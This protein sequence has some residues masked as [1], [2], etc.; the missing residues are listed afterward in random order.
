MKSL[1]F[2]IF[3]IAHAFLAKAFDSEL[4][5]S[6][7]DSIT[8]EQPEN[9][10]EIQILKYKS[11]NIYYIIYDEK[12]SNS[13]IYQIGLAD[14]YKDS[15]CA[16]G[17]TCHFFSRPLRNTAVDDSQLIRFFEYFGE[18]VIKYLGTGIN[19]ITS[20]CAL[21]NSKILESND[22]PSTVYVDGFFY[23]NPNSKLAESYK[24]KSI[25]IHAKDEES[26]LA[27][28]E[29][30]KFIS[31]FY[32]K[33]KEA[34]DIFAGVLSQYM[35]NKNL[36]QNNKL[37]ARLRIAWL[38]SQSPENEKWLTRDYEYVKNLLADAGATLTNEKEITSY[39]KVK[40]VLKQS[41]F[42]IDIS[43]GSSGE[44]DMNDFYD[45]Y[46]YDANDSL[47]LLKEQNI[48][49]ND[50]TRS[51]EGIRAWE[52]DY[53]AF[54]HLVL[55]DL[56]YW[57]HPKLFL[58]DDY[59][60][61]IVKRLYGG[62]SVNDDTPI[63][64]IPGDK[65]LE[66]DENSNQNVIKGNS[67]DTGDL[68]K[69]FHTTH[70]VS[71]YWFRNIAKNTNI[72]TEPKDRCPSLLSEYTTNNICLSDTYFRG[73]YDEYAMFDDVV[74]QVKKYAV[75]YYPIIGCVILG[76]FILALIFLKYLKRRRLEKKGYS[77]NQKILDDNEG[78]VEI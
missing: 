23:T 49:R 50:A 16:P 71:S 61:N 4:K 57:F 3:A 2:S 25:L 5:F 58:D 42:L 52:D 31:V 14:K 66:K 41:H 39:K 62:I 59:N 35:C 15:Y 36:I 8:Y 47:L 20:G 6:Y 78:F 64:S 11:D 40:Q 48:L 60:S 68:R 33:Q 29:W 38:T 69:R 21:K 70:S 32:G 10:D 77:D 1:L 54:P 12:F 9:S 19:H 26:P 34:S 37:F 7:T 22:N 65:P 24:D 44:Y 51:H 17:N 28:F 63:E 72:K 18:D 53:M 45:Q 73:D 43:S 13:T 55:L 76:S 67:T 27:K 75:I 56:I 46:R 74:T 30:I